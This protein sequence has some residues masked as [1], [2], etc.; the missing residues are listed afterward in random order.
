MSVTNCIMSLPIISATL[1]E[2]II[3]IRQIFDLTAILSLPIALSTVGSSL[4]S[5]ISV[6]TFYVHSKIKAP[7]V[8]IRI[9]I[10]KVKWKTF[11]LV[12]CKWTSFKVFLLV[13]VFSRQTLDG[14]GAFT[15][16][17]TGCR[18]DAERGRVQFFNYIAWNGLSTGCILFG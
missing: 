5:P 16:G 11:H 18:R 14:S 15:N 3:F 6:C 13:N 2:W 7:I 17:Q 9:I 8:T 12:H 1:R 10:G 4:K